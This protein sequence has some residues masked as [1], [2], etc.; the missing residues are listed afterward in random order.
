MRKQIPQLIFMSWCQIDKNRERIMTEFIPIFSTPFPRSSNLEGCKNFPR[1]IT[2]SISTPSLPQII[3]LNYHYGTNR[4]ES[5][6]SGL[7]GHWWQGRDNKFRVI[8]EI[9]ISIWTVSD[10]I[11]SP[12]SCCG[13]LEGWCSR[14]IKL[15]L[16]HITCFD[17][18][19]ILQLQKQADRETKASASHVFI[20]FT[21]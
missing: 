14:V 3:H 19:W 5:C 1:L 8:N 18:K 12:G 17:Y 13:R 4:T 10:K 7:K 11:I 21:T 15:Q 16:P 2:F 9:K 6:S 20:G